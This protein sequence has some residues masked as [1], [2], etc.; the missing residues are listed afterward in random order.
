MEG[1]NI[2]GVQFRRAGRIYDF[3][4]GDSDFKVGDDVVV[5]TERGPSLAKVAVIRYRAATPARSS[6]PSCASRPGA[7][8]R[9]R[10]SSRQSTPPPSPARKPTSS[11]PQD[12]RSCRAEVQFGGD[13]VIIFFSSP[14]RVDFRELVKELAVGLR[15]AS[16]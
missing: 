7:T 4:S 14:G 8:W 10:A 2:V 5:E 11:Q 9:R 15:R 12:E 13:K 16:S 3:S 6:K 1:I